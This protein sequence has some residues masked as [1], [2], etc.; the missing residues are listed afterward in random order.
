MV[1]AGRDLDEEKRANAKKIDLQES[2]IREFRVAH[3]LRTIWLLASLAIVGLLGWATL[4]GIWRSYP[5]PFSYIGLIAGLASTLLAARA[6]LG[7]RPGL[8]RLEYDLLVYRSD[9]VSLAAQSASNAT[10]ALRIYRVNSEEVILDYRRSATRSRRVHNFFQA[11]ILAGSVVVTSLTSAG[12]NAEWSRWTAASIAALVSISAAFTGYFKFRERSFN[13][14]Q[15]ADAIEKEYK[16]VELRI[17]KYDDDNEDL[18]LKRYAAKVEELK[19][20]QRKKELQL[21][22]SSQPEGKA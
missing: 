18:V 13:Q 4:I 20:E 21:E 8:H 19:E 16:A 7:K 2:E 5:L 17:E 22:Q 6:V 3:R 15:T 11:V 12:L 10:A 1:T 14:Q 9:Q